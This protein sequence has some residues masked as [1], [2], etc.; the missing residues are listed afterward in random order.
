L[1]LWEDERFSDFKKSK[2][3]HITKHLMCGGRGMRQRGEEGEEVEE[4]REDD[5]SKE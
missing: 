5:S 3:I 1:V 4:R 2:S